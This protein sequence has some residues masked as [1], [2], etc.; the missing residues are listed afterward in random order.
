MRSTI[1]NREFLHP[2]DGWYQIEPK[3]DHPNRASNV[4]QVLDD[5]AC[6]AIVNRFNQDA[7]TG[8]LSHGSEMLI[9]HEHF[10]YE[11]DKESLAYGWLTKLQNRDDGIYGQVRW[12]GTG[13]SAVDGGDYRFFST[14]YDPADLEILNDGKPRR[15]RPLRL[16]GL[17]LTNSPNNKG[18]RPI[19]NR[20]GTD[21]PVIAAL[22]QSADRIPTVALEAWF[23]A[24]GSIMR[25]FTKKIG[26]QMGF[27]HAWEICKQQHPDL[28]KAAF[29]DGTET[30][31]AETDAEIKV[32]GEDIAQVANRIRTLADSDFK[33][34]W[35]FVRDNL[36]H[37]FNRQFNTI[38][39]SINRVKE[40][41]DPAGIQK[42]AAKLFGQLARQEEAATGLPYSQAF[43]RV[44]NREKVLLGLSNYQISPAEA[45]AREPELRE[46]LLS[47]EAAVLKREKENADPATIRLSGT[48][49]FNRLVSQEQTTTGAS[50]MQA[51]LRVMNREKT[52]VALVNRKISPKEAF[53]SDPELRAR[54]D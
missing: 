46:R 1:L 42:K 3:G 4:V 28:Y 47:G 2:A 27:Q 40:E 5:K 24:V 6:S 43:Q 9:D 49:L 21:D 41:I 23:T 53:A 38:R 19:T 33:F 11:A 31:P 52:L 54:L 8:K 35:N 16:D 37:I 34:A 32:A 18:G 14:E 20:T 51:N 45:F 15:V 17:S 48:K 26:V 44:M 36:P 7:A 10:K 30:K 50:L 22:E 29:G 39:R 12:T 13:K 25:T